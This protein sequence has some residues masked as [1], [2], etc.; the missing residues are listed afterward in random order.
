MSCLHKRSLHSCLV[1]S[2]IGLANRQNQLLNYTNIQ[3]FLN[4]LNPNIEEISEIVQY[5]KNI[6]TLTLQS[7]LLLRRMC[8]HIYYKCNMQTAIQ[9]EYS[10]SSICQLSLCFINKQISQEYGQS[11]LYI[12]LLQEIQLNNYSYTGNTEYP[13]NQLKSQ[14]VIQASVALEQLNVL[15]NQEYKFTSNFSTELTQ[16]ITQINAYKTDVQKVFSLYFL[17]EINQNAQIQLK[18]AYLNYLATSKQQL[19]NELQL[20]QLFLLISEINPQNQLCVDYIIDI[21]DDAFSKEDQL[22]ESLYEILINT[23]NIFNEELNNIILIML[24]KIT[25]LFKYIQNL[26]VEYLDAHQVGILASKQIE[27][28]LDLQKY[29]EESQKYALAQ[30]SMQLSSDNHVEVFMIVCNIIN[31]CPNAQIDTI[32]NQLFQWHMTEFQLKTITNS[33]RSQHRV[34]SQSSQQILLSILL[35]YSNNDQ[36]YIEATT[37]LILNRLNTDFCEVECIIGLIV[38]H[39]FDISSVQI[40][41]QYYLLQCAYDEFLVNLLQHLKC[42][43]QEALIYYE[44]GNHMHSTR[45]QLYLLNM[46]LTNQSYSNVQ[47]YCQNL[48]QRSDFVQEL[49]TL[50]RILGFDFLDQIQNIPHDCYD[51]LFEILVLQ[52]VQGAIQLQVEQLFRV[53]QINTALHD[54]IYP[55]LQSTDLQILL[56]K[57][58][59]QSLFP[60]EII[61]ILQNN[62]TQQE[63]IYLQRDLFQ[64][65][66]FFM[67]EELRSSSV[68]YLNQNI[69]QN[70][71][72][73]TLS[74]VN[75]PLL[76]PFFSFPFQFQKKLSYF[77]ELILEIVLNK[78]K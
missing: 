37:N 38:L 53:K 34:I 22:K 61:I 9:F 3:Q 23:V 2:L 57:F 26:K 6:N 29:S 11:G 77:Q 21:L 30:L 19:H 7:Q 47:Q 56:N 43:T 66:S 76:N 13:P 24:Y 75:F 73:K 28:I 60:Q 71:F 15:I 44:G 48:S 8:Q 39:K 41:L 58:E 4:D 72:L 59:V 18:I 36:Q 12:Q 25:G 27:Q 65:S 46:A 69:N 16:L 10:T 49:K 45:I 52:V 20:N 78:I 50:T 68:T 67:S 42:V 32:L 35:L 14:Y 54:W 55:F 62:F 63:Y 1:C 40:Y 31:H 70:V 51:V 64:L 74:K 5:F 33:I 17:D